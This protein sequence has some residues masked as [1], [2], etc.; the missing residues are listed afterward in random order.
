M[1]KQQLA[2]RHALVAAQLHEAKLDPGAKIHPSVVHFDPKKSTV[3][4]LQ[5]D[6]YLERVPVVHS[7]VP[8]EPVFV[9]SHDRFIVGKRLS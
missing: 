4:L 6:G 7:Q 8:L 2:H 5:K 1:N 3:T 9:Y